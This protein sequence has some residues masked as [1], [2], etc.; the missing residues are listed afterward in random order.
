MIPTDS[1][2][3]ADMGDC[4]TNQSG[5]A[6]FLGGSFSGVNQPAGCDPDVDC[7]GDQRI[8]TRDCTIPA[9]K[10]IFLPIANWAWN[11]I[12]EDPPATPEYMDTF[13]DS[14]NSAA[15]N[16]VVEIDGVELGNIENYR[17]HTQVFEHPF[18][19]A[20]PINFGGVTEDGWTDAV[21]DGYWVFLS[22]PSPGTH[23]IHFT[24]EFNFTTA[25][26]G[27]DWLTELDFTYNITVE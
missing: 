11:N 17:V 25:G 6:F 27:F 14:W 20:G 16:M 5:A 22:P 13:V 10:A 18:L 24:S 2:P 8:A 26:Q 23:T 19:A 9:G 15:Q 1:H 4:D 12:G 3:L 7:T 21:S